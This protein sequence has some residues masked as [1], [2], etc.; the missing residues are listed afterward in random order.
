MPV[1][2]FAVWQSRLGGRRGSGQP[3]LQSRKA[4]L[5]VFIFLA[6]ALGHLTHRI[7]FLALDQIHFAQ[8][9]LGLTA[10]DGL[11]LR[12]Q[13]WAAPAA[14]VTNLANSSRNLFCVWV[15]ISLLSPS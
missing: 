8:K 4:R 1:E 15:M 6:C 10:H 12:L 3:G 13:S 14:S 5:E 11:D 2:K 7:E 9:S